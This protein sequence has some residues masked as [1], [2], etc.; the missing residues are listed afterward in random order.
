[1]LLEFLKDIEMKASYCLRREGIL[2]AVRFKK[3]HMA[4]IKEFLCRKYQFATPESLKLNVL[5]DLQGKH[6]LEQIRKKPLHSILFNCYDDLDVDLKESSWWLSHGN[7][8]PRSEG[9]L[10]MVQDRNLFF[11]NGG[12]CC[13]HCNAAKKTVD[14][15]A[16]R[17]GRMLN[18]DYLRRYN[19]VV[20]C[21]HLHICRKYGIK[22]S[23]K[24]KTHSVQ[25]TVSNEVVEIRVDTTIK[26]D[27][28]VSN[29]KP[30]IFVFDKVRNIITLIKIGITSQ[31]SLKQ[32][33]VEKL[34]KYDLLANELKVIHNAKV[35]IIPLVITWD[36]IT[37]RFYK[38][39]QN[40]LQ[41]Q[42][43]TRAYIQSIVIKRTLESMRPEYKLLPTATKHAIKSDS[44][45]ITKVACPVKWIN[46]PVEDTCSGSKRR[47]ID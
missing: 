29:N 45:T 40:S 24:L 8:S 25:S 3:T 23:R 28:I 27:T 26:T 22:Q 7:N 2:K 16:T 31:Q 13:N 36:G 38:H 14:H 41:V 6:L 12:S 30:D 10:C 46:V 34:H 11:D 17:C 15:L 21:M 47:R 44:R 9:M 39:Y 20:R 32:V 5:K 42:E 4:T 1:M 37:S 43:S 35:N 18:S 19:E 33:E